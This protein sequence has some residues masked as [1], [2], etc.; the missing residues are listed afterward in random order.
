MSRKDAPKVHDGGIRKIGGFRQVIKMTGAILRN[1]IRYRNPFM[2]LHSVT[3]ACQ[4]ACPY[5]PWAHGKRRPDEL[6][7]PE[8]KRLY[9]EARGL[10]MRYVH[11]WGGEPLTHPKI[12]EIAAHA[13]AC[14]LIT[15]MITNGGLLRRRAD[16]LIPY[17]NRLNVSLDYPGT[18]HNEMRATLGL[19]E[20][21]IAGIEYVR[22]K[23]PKQPILLSFTLCKDNRDAVREAAYLAR[24]LGVRLY[25]NPMRA[26]AL[27][28]DGGE[29]E[30]AT[31]HRNDSAFDVDN[32]ARVIPWAD[33]REVWETLISLKKAGYPIQNTHYYMKLIA[34]SGRAPEYRC[35]WP[36]MCVAIDANG[37]IVD[38]QRWNRPIASVRT[39]PLRDI[40]Q[41]PRMREL[42]GEAGES[43]SACASP[44]RVEPSRMWGL[45]PGM[46][47][48]AI[49]SLIL[50]R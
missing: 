13:V 4:A 18:K 20:Q 7:L 48:G 31:R 40:V 12:G 29:V 43:C 38:C 26:G 2:L 33:Q 47:T 42:Y 19:Y 35:H 14:G 6:T 30:D 28:S 50:R 16:E 45:H 17:L 39:T 24:Q 10:R 5:C 32:S 44:A 22:S 3:E 34:R 46:V 49:S 1:R 23:W 27:V 15:G 8:I 21:L 9:E 37:D 25:I 41:L 11:F 36:K